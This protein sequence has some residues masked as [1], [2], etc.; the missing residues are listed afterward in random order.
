MDN[1]TAT[2]RSAQISLI[3]YYNEILRRI[4]ILFYILRSFPNESKMNFELIEEL[5]KNTRILLNVTSMKDDHYDSVFIENKVLFCEY[6]HVIDTRLTHFMNILVEYLEYV[7]AVFD[8]DI[9]KYKK[10][11]EEMMSLLDS[12]LRRM[13]NFTISIHEKFSNDCYEVVED[14]TD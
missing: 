6:A 2:S 10:K 1:W 13:A 5:D 9:E 14:Q 11:K 8:K 12:I 4:N 7:K 3:A